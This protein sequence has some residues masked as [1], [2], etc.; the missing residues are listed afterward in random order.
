M[1]FKIIRND[2]TKVAADAIVNTANPDPEYA[3]GVD[4][5]IYAAAGA[6]A[7]LAERKKIGEMNVGQAA[8]TPAFALDAKYIIHTVGPAWVDG[9]HGEFDNLRTCYENSLRLALEYGCESIAF[10]LIATGVYGFPKA[11]ALRIAISVFSDFLMNEDME[12]ILV[13]FDKESFV[14]SDKVF[15]DVDSYIDEK[16]ASEQIMEEYGS[17]EAYK[18]LSGNRLGRLFSGR[19][20]VSKAAESISYAQEDNAAFEV[21]EEAEDD[22]ADEGPHMF[23]AMAMSAP[24]KADTFAGSSLDERVSHVADTWQESLLHLIDEKGYTDTEV[25]KRANVDRKLFSKIRGNS[26]YQPKKITAVAF[27]LALKLNLDETKDLL[28]RAGYALSPSSK[29]DLIIEYFIEHEVYDTYT[30]NLALFDH[31]QPTLGE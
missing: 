13:V 16:Y 30:I 7:L 8:V 28:G 18:S 23:A 14:L 17:E 3:A 29:F 19:G 26:A 11:E 22:L 25:Y 6:E 12:I 24:M 10:P 21:E 27:A 1:A 20:R 2:I 5:A 31:D 15:S 9:K 4:G